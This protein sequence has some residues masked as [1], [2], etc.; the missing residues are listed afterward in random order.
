MATTTIGT[1]T[2]AATDALAV[3]DD[4]V[5]ADA[6]DD[7][8]TI[9]GCCGGGSVFSPHATSPTT[10]NHRIAPFMGAL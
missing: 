6:E 4:D 3:A 7:A 9:G 1:G 5:D 8:A 10:I 2:G